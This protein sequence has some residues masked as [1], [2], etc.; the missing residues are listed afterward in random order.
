MLKP[1]FSIYTLSLGKHIDLTIRLKTAAAAGFTH[2][3]LDTADWYAYADAYRASRDLPAENSQYQAGAAQQLS[4]QIKALGLKV[5]CI[6]PFRHFEG[7]LDAEARAA[8]FAEALALFHV[9][10]ILE[11]D[12]FM[13]PSSFLPAPL[14][15]GDPSRIAAD[16]RAL[17]DLAHTVSPALKIGYEALAWGTHV[18]TWQAAW[19]AVQRAD[20]AN[21]GLVLDSFNLLGR[22]YADPTREDGLAAGDADAVLYASLTELVASVPPARIFLLQ[23]ADGARVHV[24]VPPPPSAAGSAAQQQQQHPPPARLTWSRT[25]RLFPGEYDRGAYLPVVQFMQAVVSRLGFAG[26][27][28]LEYFNADLEAPHTDPDADAEIAGKLAARGMASLRWLLDVVDGPRMR[29]Q[30]A[31]SRAHQ[32]PEALGEVTVA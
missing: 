31:V 28:S 30:P 9:M 3:E 11:T 22:V 27:W 14:I 12:L 19:A 18:N 13:I 25:S 21:L 17:A 5:L 7:L 16:L 26:P 8:R 29:V 24:H 20:R 23:I 4:A 15:S 2:I 1:P 10:P 6:Q 32:L